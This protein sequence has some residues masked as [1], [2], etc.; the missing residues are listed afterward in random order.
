MGLEL[1]G[2]EG[3]KDFQAVSHFTLAM[4][5]EEACKI[6][7]RP[8]G[9]GNPTFGAYPSHRHQL[10]GLSIE[11]KAQGWWWRGRASNQQRSQ[12]GTATG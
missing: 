3:S 6:R 11:D 12:V 4:W 10:Y 8:A 7:S 5:Q 1:Q 2:C 9:W